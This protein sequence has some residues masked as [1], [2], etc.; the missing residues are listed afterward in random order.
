ME[1]IRGVYLSADNNLARVIEFN[2]TE[3]RSAELLGCFFVG[4]LKRK[5]NGRWY[6]FTF[7]N[8]VQSEW[9]AVPTY[10]DKVDGIYGNVLVT[11]F[12]KENML[13]IAE[14]D[15]LDALLKA[16]ADEQGKVIGTTKIEV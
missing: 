14:D 2:D 6:M 8:E 12:T 11:G 13:S 1:K 10:D 15:E 3:D 16:L 7:D 9:N 5:I 4:R